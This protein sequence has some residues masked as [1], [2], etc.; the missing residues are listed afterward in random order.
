[1][2]RQADHYRLLADPTR[3]AIMEALGD[4]P[5][6]VAELAATTGVH[7]NTVR[8][9]LTR[10][11]E[12]GVLATESTLPAGRGRPALRYRLREP[13]PIDGHEFRVLVDALLRLLERA[14]RRDATQVGE[15]EGYEVGRRLSSLARVPSRQLA[16]RRV[17]DVLRHLSFDPRLTSKGNVA[18]IQLRACPFG[19]RE[20]DAQGAIVCAF[21]LGLIRGVAE[22]S[23]LSP[24]PRVELHPHLLPN[25]C[26]TRIAFEAQAG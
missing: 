23:G 7:R 9:H 8:A 4:G 11:D 19:V 22:T 12:A 20:D 17:M 5:R 18:E 1:M 26:L 25:A 24:R 14:Y 2:R 16:I 3:L 21:H 10:L 15:R 6:E 13:L